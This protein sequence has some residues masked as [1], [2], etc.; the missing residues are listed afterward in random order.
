MVSTPISFPAIVS[1][2]I[3]NTC[4]NLS[5][6]CISLSSNENDIIASPK[7]TEVPQFMFARNLLHHLKTRASYK[8]TKHSLRLDENFSYFRLSP[9]YISSLGIKHQL[10]FFMH[11]IFH[12]LSMS[13]VRPNIPGIIV[14]GEEGIGKTHFLLTAAVAS[15]VLLGVSTIC[16]DCKKI[17]AKSTSLKEILD[18]LTDI[19]QSA[20]NQSPSLVLLDNLDSLAFEVDDDEVNNP[21]SN[22]SDQAK[23]IAD[24]ILSIFAEFGF[25]N[26]HNDTTAKVILICSGRHYSRIHSSLR[27]PYRLDLGV[28]LNPPDLYLRI[29]L[30]LCMTKSFGMRGCLE[31]ALEGI[32][33]GRRTEVS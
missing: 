2:P 5:M 11:Y 28:E 16:I 19:F 25:S 23:V 8:I 14:S 31:Q 20:Y 33:F 27:I 3:Q 32:S 22:L 29:E 15:R 26:E 10:G 30:F 6:W 13:D 18:K 24:H 7:T 17:Q 21:N 1:F 9:E 4:G 12:Y